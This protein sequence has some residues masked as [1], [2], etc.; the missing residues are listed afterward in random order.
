LALLYPK[1]GIK[2]LYPVSEK[3]AGQNMKA[4]GR[5]EEFIDTK[6]TFNL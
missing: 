6:L 3:T 1:T 5:E 4:S 2:F